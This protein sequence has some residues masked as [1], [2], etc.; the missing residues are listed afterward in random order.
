M[1]YGHTSSKQAMDLSFLSFSHNSIE[2]LFLFHSMEAASK[3]EMSTIEDGGWKAT[4]AAVAARS[5]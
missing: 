5:L 1:L 2:S 3:K 4:A